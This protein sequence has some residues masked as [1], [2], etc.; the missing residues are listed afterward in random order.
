MLKASTLPLRP[1]A[2]LKT[3]SVIGS[4]LAASAAAIKYQAFEHFCDWARHYEAMQID[5]LM[6]VALIF[7]FAFLYLLV[8]RELEIRRQVRSLE[9]DH[10]NAVS[11]AYQDDLTG[12]PNRRAFTERLRSVHISGHLNLA[13]LMLDL[14]GFKSVNDRL[15]H[16]KGDI[17]L[18]CVASRLK[19]LAERTQGVFAARLGGDEF[20]CIVETSFDDA[21]PHRLADT[22]VNTIGEPMVECLG[23]TI[24][25]SVGLAAH[26]AGA[27]M[28]QLMRQADNAMYSAK[29]T[30]GHCYVGA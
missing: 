9:Q 19:S 27:S 6:P 10:V 20:A 23:A 18:R 14:D 4:A 24:G 5:E 30:G 16:D 13:V 29:R 15:G 26:R 22:I 25:V 12:L 11:I 1:S 28:D 3:I 21:L 8:V 17:V 7:C 2:N